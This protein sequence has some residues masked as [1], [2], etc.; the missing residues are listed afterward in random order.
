MFSEN[1]KSLKQDRQDAEIKT[2]IKGID[3]SEPQGIAVYRANIFTGKCV[4]DAKAND[5]IYR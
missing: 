2:C 4:R 5:C 3:K 1:G